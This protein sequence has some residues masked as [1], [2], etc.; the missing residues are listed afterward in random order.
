MPLEMLLDAYRKPRRNARDRIL[1]D[2]VLRVA[3]YTQ[4][5]AMLGELTYQVALEDTDCSEF[6]AEWL[7]DGS[8]VYV[9]YEQ[10]EVGE[11]PSTVPVVKRVYPDGTWESFFRGSDFR[12]KQSMLH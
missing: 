6:R 8:L 3:A 2:A 12:V 10:E 4:E 9:G 7:P 5:R 11:E 1:F